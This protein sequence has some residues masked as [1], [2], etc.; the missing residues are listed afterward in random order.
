MNMKKICLQECLN[1][2]G[3]IDSNNNHLLVLSWGCLSLE[4]SKVTLSFL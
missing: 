4:L 3:Q 1:F 2:R